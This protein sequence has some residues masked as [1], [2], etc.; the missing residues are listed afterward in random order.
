MRHLCMI[1]AALSMVCSAAQAQDAGDTA[2]GLEY[3]QRHCAECHGVLPGDRESSRPPIATFRSIANTPGMTGTALAVWLR[4]PHKNMP[5][6]IVAA[7]D[8][9]DLIAYILSLRERPR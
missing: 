2:R 9:A 1:A 8:R 7:E 3:A 5:N 6:L 4:T